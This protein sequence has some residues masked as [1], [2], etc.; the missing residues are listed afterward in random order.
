MLIRDFYTLEE[1]ATAETKIV[2]K[3]KLNTGHEVYKGHFPGQPVVPGVIQLQ[4]AREIME[5]SLGKKL[6]LKEIIQAK[7]LQPIDPIVFPELE[8]QLDYNEFEKNSFKINALILAKEN[9]FT[10]IR[11]IVVVQN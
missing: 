8:I 3:I 10:K 7:Y 6:F 2:A 5:E 4:V 11:A 1:L 9:T